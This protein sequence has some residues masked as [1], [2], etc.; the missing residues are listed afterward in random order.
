MKTSETDFQPGGIDERLQ[1]SLDFPPDAAARVARGALQ[2]SGPSVRFRPAR[3][4]WLPLAAVLGLGLAGGLYLLRS[5]VR[6]APRRPSITNI[7]VVLIATNPQGEGRLLH[8]AGAPEP[9]GTT[10]IV[11]HGGTK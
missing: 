3:K 9:S 11:R 4:R 8:S 2:A 7:G 6:P 10:W 5:P 1:R